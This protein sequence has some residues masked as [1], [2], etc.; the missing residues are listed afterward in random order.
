MAF[1]NTAILKARSSSV[2]HWYTHT[3]VFSCKSTK[4]SSISVLVTSST[5][6]VFFFRLFRVP[7]STAGSS[8]AALRNALRCFSLTSLGGRTTRVSWSESGRSSLIQVSLCTDT[9]SEMKKWSSRKNS[10]GVIVLSL[11]HIFL[12]SIDNKSDLLAT[13]DILHI[14]CK[15]N[16]CF[17]AFV[18]TIMASYITLQNKSHVSF[19]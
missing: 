17:R 9:G 6:S 1:V 15:I 12:Q 19:L 14:L 10:L 8:T 18:N 4:A 3:L 2:S 5:A 7:S 11:P 16:Q 13:I